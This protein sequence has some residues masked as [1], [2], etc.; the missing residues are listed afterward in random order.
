MGEEERTEGKGERRR[1]FV[2]GGALLFVDGE[3]RESPSPQSSPVE[4]EEAGAP[5]PRNP[6]GFRLG[7]RNDGWVEGE[8]GGAP[9]PRNPS[10]M[11][12]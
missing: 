1:V 11:F 8:E 7:G 12:R 2:S 5:S 4:G 10:C 3:E 6:A 9:S